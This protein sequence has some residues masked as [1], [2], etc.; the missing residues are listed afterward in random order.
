VA[1]D[2]D[3]FAEWYSDSTFEEATMPLTRRLWEMYGEGS[4]RENGLLDL[5]VPYARKWPGRVRGT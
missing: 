4:G 2:A 3:K 5:W 1:A